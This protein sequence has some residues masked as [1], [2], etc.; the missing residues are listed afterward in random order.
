[1]G[2]KPT[3]T[4]QPYKDHVHK[5][6]NRTKFFEH[7]RQPMVGWYASQLLSTALDLLISTTLSSSHDI[8]LLNVLQD[9]SHKTIIDESQRDEMWID[10]IADTGDGF[11]SS[12]S[13]VY[14]Q[15]QPVLETEDPNHLYVEKGKIITPRGSVLFLGGDLAYPTPSIK[16]YNLRFKK[17]F[18]MAFP[19][20]DKDVPGCEN[21]NPPF[22]APRCY[23]IPGNHDW[24]DS[25][26]LY[27]TLFLNSHNINYVDKYEDK[28]REYDELDVDQPSP[29]KKPATGASRHSVWLGGYKLGQDQSYFA[30]KLPQRWWV[31]GLDFGLANDIDIS[32]LRY[33][34]WTLES[35]MDPKDDGPSNVILMCH[36]P[37]WWF[38]KFKSRKDWPM[39]V[40]VLLK[41]I[42][43]NGHIARLWLGGDVHNYRRDSSDDSKYHKIIAGGGGAFLHPTGFDACNN[44]HTD[45]TKREQ[46]QFL[47]RKVYPSAKTCHHLNLLNMFFPFYNPYFGT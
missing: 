36:E 34:L 1:M 40:R 14:K 20:A 24:Y 25:L 7:E 33:F 17:L 18:E 30:C 43:K 10:F 8:R 6:Q 26:T 9:P 28:N 37:L 31:F 15:T 47:R 5:L 4:H 23:A 41:R 32:Q 44:S 45:D 39:N 42:E 35:E 3:I 19:W 2:N 11:D 46:I 21:L 16:S 29:S 38:S 13:V 27:S 22:Y 12:Y